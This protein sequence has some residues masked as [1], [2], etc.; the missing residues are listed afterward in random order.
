M[1]TNEIFETA[2]TKA[3]V[4]GSTATCTVNLPYSWYL[5]MSSA[6]TAALSYTLEIAN[7]SAPL[8][9]PQSRYSSQFVPGAG[10]IKVPANGTTTTYTISAT[11]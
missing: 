2:S 7:A 1:L 11:L 4:S 3:T 9:N 6:D 8:A 10:A 5:T